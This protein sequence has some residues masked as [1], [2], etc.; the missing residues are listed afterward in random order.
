LK[1][2]GHWDILYLP[3]SLVLFCV[4]FFVVVYAK[5]FSPFLELTCV[6]SDL[7]L[8]TFF[9]DVRTSNDLTAII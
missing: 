3:N 8:A 4:V 5:D 7:L 2:V 1:F 6:F 9:S